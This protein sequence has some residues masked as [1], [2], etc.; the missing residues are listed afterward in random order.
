MK[1]VV[2]S[3]FCLLLV[4]SPASVPD[5]IYIEKHMMGIQGGGALNNAYWP[6]WVG[7]AWNQPETYRLVK[8][9]LARPAEELYHTVNDPY[10]MTNLAAD[11]RYAAT[12]ARLSAELDRWLSSQGDPGVPQDTHEAHG[13]ATQGKHRYF[14]KP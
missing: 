14:P 11:S 3:L 7:N 10:E 9:Y 2:P 12:K 6:T 4:S 8:R 5:E 1:L 13:D